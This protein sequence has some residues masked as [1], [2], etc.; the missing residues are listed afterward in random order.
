MCQT[1]T[2]SGSQF[3]KNIRSIDQDRLRRGSEENDEGEPSGPN[4]SA[5][6]DGLAPFHSL[7]LAA[8]WEKPVPSRSL[9]F[10]AIH[11]DEAHQIQRFVHRRQGVRPE[12]REC[13]SVIKACV[14]SPI[15]V[16]S[17]QILCLVVKSSVPKSPNR[18]V[19][20]Q[21]MWHL[22]LIMWSATKSCFV[23]NFINVYF[24]N[25]LYPADTWSNTWTRHFTTWPPSHF[26]IG[27]HTAIWNT[28]RWISTDWSWL[29]RIC[30]LKL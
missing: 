4:L 21:I 8:G 26:T 30:H 23:H 13:H 27:K 29:T 16:F 14:L 18:T 1:W 15:H 5:R 19:C 9:R 6:W 11:P 7:S 17:H 12:L 3:K 10:G 20:H 22:S 24:I 28:W 25:I 2:V